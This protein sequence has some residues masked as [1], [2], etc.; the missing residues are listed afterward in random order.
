[1][2]QAHLKWFEDPLSVVAVG[3][4]GIDWLLPIFLVG[5]GIVVFWLIDK[6]SKDIN[7]VVS[8]KLAFLRPYVP[9]VVGLTIGLSLMI[10][11]LSGHLFAAN[12]QIENSIIL[13]LEFVIGLLL[14]L[15]LFT[16]HGAFGL[17]VLY[18][19]SMFVSPLGGVGEHLEYVGAA[20]FL[21]IMGGGS[22]TI[23]KLLIKKNYFKDLEKYKPY[24]LT[25]FCFLTGLSLSVLAFTEKLLNLDLAEKFLVTHHWNLLSFFGVSNHWF[26]IIIGSFEL[27]MGVLIAFR[28]ATR[29]VV[30]MLAGVMAL[31]AIILGPT[32]VG[33]HLFAIGLA[34]AVWVGDEK[35][36]IKSKEQLTHKK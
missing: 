33:G 32:E 16:R 31:T 7:L 4:I 24:A 19:V 12:V 6:F 1:M 23:D 15:G 21:L 2:I 29:L 8:S 22:W 11:A 18:G 20:I 14:A 10:Y 9:S 28:V 35:L 25:V 27:L 5:G 30:A 26:I 36:T 3:I 34:M 17:L 13:G